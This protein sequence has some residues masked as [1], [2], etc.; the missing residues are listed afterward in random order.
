MHPLRDARGSGVLL[1]AS[2]NAI[3]P[4]VFIAVTS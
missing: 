1:L 2:A 4:G 3:G